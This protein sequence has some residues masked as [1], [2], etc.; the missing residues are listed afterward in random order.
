MVAAGRL[1]DIGRVAIVLDPFDEAFA[2]CGRDGR[3]FAVRHGSALGADRAAI[4]GDVR[5]TG[6]AGVD[7]LGVED[8]RI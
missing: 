2:G 7:H 3:V 8:R 4:F 5:A 1:G 6:H